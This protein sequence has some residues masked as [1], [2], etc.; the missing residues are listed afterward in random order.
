MDRDSDLCMHPLP[1]V[2]P[3]IE[4]MQIWHERTHADRLRRWFRQQV[5]EIAM[6]LDANAHM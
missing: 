1:L 5:Q 4:L 6:Q 3:R 2:L